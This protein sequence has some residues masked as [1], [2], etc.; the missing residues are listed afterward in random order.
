M[1][2]FVSG[3]VFV[4]IGIVLKI[5]AEKEY[6]SYVVHKAADDLFKESK[7]EK[8]KSAFS[9]VSKVFQEKSR[10]YPKLMTYSIIS[11]VIG[12]ALLFYS[13]TTTVPR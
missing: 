1:L 10:H 13:L 9:L 8:D 4:I 2:A 3:I 11:T 12:M 7:D 5:F 6:V